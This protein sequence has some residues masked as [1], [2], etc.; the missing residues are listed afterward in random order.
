MSFLP[1]EIIGVPY[2]IPFRSQSVIVL[3]DSY[4]A[5]QKQILRK[6]QVSFGGQRCHNTLTTH[7]FHEIWP[8]K[9]CPFSRC[10]L[11]T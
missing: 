11:K 1:S 3:H 10:K 2:I 9:S 6:R 4:S 8:D 5:F 7:D